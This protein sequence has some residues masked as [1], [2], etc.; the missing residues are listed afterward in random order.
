M[1]EEEKYRGL[2]ISEWL[3]LCSRELFRVA[4]NVKMEPEE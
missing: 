2:E 1:L 4:A 3:S